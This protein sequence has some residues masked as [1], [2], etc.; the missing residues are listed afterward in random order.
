MKAAFPCAFT[1][2]TGPSLSRNAMMVVHF[3]LVPTEETAA[4]P[5]WGRLVETMDREIRAAEFGRA[6]AS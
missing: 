4:R 2:G 3:S 6:E 5:A 1:D